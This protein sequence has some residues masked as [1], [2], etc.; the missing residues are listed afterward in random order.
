MQRALKQLSDAE[1]IAMVISLAGEFASGRQ[2]KSNELSDALRL[3]AGQFALSQT[4]ENSDGNLARAA[5]EW[6]A[7]DSIGLMMIERRL[8]ALPE[9]TKRRRERF[10]DLSSPALLTAVLVLLQVRFRIERDTEGKWSFLLEKRAASDTVLKT[11][12]ERLIPLL[13][14]GNDQPGGIVPNENQIDFVVLFALSKELDAFLRLLKEYTTEE[15]GNLKFHRAEIKLHDGQ[16]YRLIVFALSRMGNYEAAA[17]TT[18]AINVWN[19]RFILLGGIT[20]GVKRTGYELGDVIVADAI[21]G[22][23]PG[24]QKDDGLHRRLHFLRPAGELIDAARNLEPADW[25]L[26]AREERPDGSDRTIPK[27]HFG[28]VVSGEKVIASKPWFDELAKDVH[29]ASEATK[30][31]GVEMEGY[32]TALAAFNAATAPGMLMAKAICDW[33]DSSKNDGWQAYAAAVSAAFLIALLRKR[34][35]APAVEKK[36]QAERRDEKPYSSKSKLGLCRHMN[37]EWEDL[38]DYYDIPLSERRVFRP[39]RE[40]QDLW[41]WLEVRRKLGSLPDGLKEIGRE[42]L[43]QELIPC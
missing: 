19:P 31:A 10:S 28:A 7:C 16:R 23:E 5:L 9:A 18:R 32:G 4:T 6:F 27:V 17:A 1:A 25:A 39:G 15:A 42:D 13:Q 20:G 2:K 33:A 21:V 3:L 37:H 38:A 26:R 22:Y 8:G 30:I 12:L 43:I 29:A 35:V 24:K 34:P 36:E 11:L 14:R 40:C 41:N